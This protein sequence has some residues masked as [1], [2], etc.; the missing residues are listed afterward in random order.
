[1]DNNVVNDTVVADRPVSASNFSENM[2]V[3]AATGADTAMT[4]AT[5]TVPVMEQAYK[6]KIIKS[7]D[8]ISRNT[9]DIQAEV[10][11]TLKLALAR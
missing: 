5:I 10:P 3:A 11:L 1:M 8:T 6:P 9:M 2:V 7:G 4:Q